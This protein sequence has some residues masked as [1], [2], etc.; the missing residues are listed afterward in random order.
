MSVDCINQ[1]QELRKRKEYG[2]FYT[3][4]E[5]SIPLT[6]IAIDQ[7]LVTKINIENGKNYTS[8]ESILENKNRNEHMLL[9]E[10]I[11]SLKILDGAVGDGEFLKNSYRYL[12]EIKKQIYTT[13][14]V[15]NDQP[16][17]K[18]LNNLFG[19]EINKNSLLKCKQNLQRE[20]LDEIKGELLNQNFITGNFLNAS[21]ID[22]G[23]KQND[24]FD[25][26]LSNP[27]WGGKLSKAEK[28]YFQEKFK[29]KSPKRNLNTFSLF[30]YQ[31]TLLLKQNSG[32]LA[33]ILPKNITRSNQYTH[34]RHHLLDNYQIL[35]LNFHGLFDGVIQE[36]VSIVGLHKKDNNCKNLINIDNKR[37]IP[38]GVYLNN[39]DFVFS[40]EYDESSQKLLE[41][42]KTG[43]SKIGDY[44]TIHR[45]EELSKKG[46]IM[47][48]SHCDK[49][50]V[51]SSRKTLI[52]CSQCGQNLNQEDLRVK[53]IIKQ[54][55]N[56]DYNQEILTGENIKAFEITRSYYIIP[57][58]QFKSKKPPAIYKSPKIVIQKIKRVPCAAIDLKSRWTTQ[59]VYNLQLKSEIHHQEELVY[60]F[61]AV[62]NSSLYSW[63]YETQFNLGSRYTNAISIHN[64]KRLPV[65]TPKL[66][67]P[68]FTEIIEQTKSMIKRNQV[69]KKDKKVLNH[70]VLKLFD[71]TEFSDY[72]EASLR[73]ILL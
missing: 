60:Y 57:D 66:E 53:Y 43:N 50:V 45:G 65:I 2:V 52:I 6:K 35:N 69:Y 42:I 19:M 34:L 55:K 41:K 16:D 48:C 3:P 59:N 21:P 28:D 25:V 61:T 13:S 63:F 62:L 51:L 37:K 24:L 56:N 38:Q 23:L 14:G 4:P 71:C 44:F 18:I 20:Q 54:E 58:F 31:A 9:L 15:N 36:F 49:W 22:W 12:R 70:L 68:V 5:F 30:I 32:I 11:N 26:I 67:N 39:L 33:Y 17:I 10:Q 72:I 7:S 1:N 29:L 73:K 40:F 8:I 46:G 47:F 27:P 64:L